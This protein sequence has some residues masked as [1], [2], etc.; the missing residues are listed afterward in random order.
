MYLYVPTE[1]ER[2]NISNRTMVCHKHQGKSRNQ[3][4]V[5]ASMVSSNIPESGKRDGTA[6][7]NII[8]CIPRHGTD[9]PWPET[10]NQ[11]L[12]DKKRQAEPRHQARSRQATSRQERAVLEGEGKDLT[13]LEDL[14]GFGGLVS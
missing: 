9:S 4:N 7:Q 5:T 11:G 6:L 2:A 14:C 10:Q 3:D 12:D 13:V 1:K 8:K